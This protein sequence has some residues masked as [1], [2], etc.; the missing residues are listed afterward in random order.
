VGGGRRG[1]SD[2]VREGE[3]GIWNTAARFDL[4]KTSQT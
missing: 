4:C 2:T 3:E 1:R